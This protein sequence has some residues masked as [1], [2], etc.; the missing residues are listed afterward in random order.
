LI[1]RY[2]PDPSAGELSEE[3]L[4]TAYEVGDRTIP[5]LRANMVSSLDGAV[6]VDGLSAGLSS[7]EDRRML[8]RL[9]MLT[10][11]LL[12]GAGTLRSEGY[13]PL[14]LSPER[15]AWR[16]ENGLPDNPVLVV[17]SGRLDLSPDAR[18][19]GEAPV[20]PLVITHAAAPADRRKELEAVAD[21]VVAGEQEVRAEA[22]VGTLVDRGLPQILCEGGPRLLGTLLAADLLDELCLSVSPLLAGPG[23]GRIIDGPPSAVRRLAQ[24]H[25]LGADDG[26]LFLRYLRD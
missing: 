7:V 16:R 19:L 15:Q 4:V 20:R 2:A 14:R 9:R 25:I 10:D 26:V 12:V 3:D 1:R 18:A 24:R 23:S 11:A 13:N 6:E 8:S 21:I 17:V 22:I 5:H